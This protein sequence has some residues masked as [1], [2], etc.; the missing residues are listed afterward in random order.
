MK[1]A[2]LILVAGFCGLTIWAAYE[3]R[4]IADGLNLTFDL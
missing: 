2:A 3:G 1:L 4:K